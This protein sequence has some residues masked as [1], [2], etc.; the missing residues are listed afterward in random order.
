[1]QEEL[2]ATLADLQKAPIPAEAATSRCTQRGGCAPEVTAADEALQL[3]ALGGAVTFQSE[4][5]EETDLCELAR[6]VKALLA[7]FTEA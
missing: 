4:Q 2:A 3:T 5:C 7:K 6:N 1:M